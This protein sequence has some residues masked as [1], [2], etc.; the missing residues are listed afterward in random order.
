MI[1]KVIVFFVSLVHPF[2]CLAQMNSSNLPNNLHTL[3]KKAVIAPFALIGYGFSVFKI[4]E[5]QRFNEELREEILENFDDY[6]HSDDYLQYLPAVSALS[7][8]LFSP[9][10]QAQFKRRSSIIS[11]SMLTM[12]SVVTTLKYTTRVRRPDGSSRNS[13]PSGHTA[14]AFA[15]AEFLRQELSGNSS[16]YAVTGYALAAGIGYFRM[17][18]NRH[19]FTD[20]TAGAGIGILS[21]QLAY[22][23]DSHRH[24]QTS[25]SRFLFFLPE[26]SRD[27]Q[28]LRIV[29]QF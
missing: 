2:C 17:Y 13:F 4:G 23:W 24:Q 26:W 28:R 16:W 8:S 25:N 15:G 11:I 5:T 1:A 18:N 21:T 29:T 14:T 10:Q 3:T 6:F 27:T 19:W 20:V 7:L 12:A 9:N 22:W